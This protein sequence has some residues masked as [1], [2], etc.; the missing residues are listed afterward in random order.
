[1]DIILIS[2]PNFFD[3]EEQIVSA[4]L[5]RFDLTFHLRKPGASYREY[6]AFLQNI[7]NNLHRKIV[8]HGAYSLNERYDLMGLHFS[9]RNRALAEV[10]PSVVKS[11]SAHSVQESRQ[12]DGQF[13]YQFLSPVFP[14]ISKKGYTGNLDMEEV[15]GFLQQTRQSRVIALGGVDRQRISALRKMGFD[16]MALLGAAWD[17]NPPGGV[18]VERRLEEFLAQVGGE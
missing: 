17:E 12:L 7:P 1:M 8:L 15:S 11:T 13:H 18:A 5:N 6:Q 2:R 16:G 4:L 9:T 14:S 3:G 10:Y